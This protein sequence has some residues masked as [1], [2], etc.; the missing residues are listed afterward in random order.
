MRN[1]VHLWFHDG[2]RVL[3]DEIRQN[4]CAEAPVGNITCQL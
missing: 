4:D 1:Y 3:L 2:M